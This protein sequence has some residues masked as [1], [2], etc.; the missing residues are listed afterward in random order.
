M[1]VGL[2]SGDR[3]GYRGQTQ[4]NERIADEDIGELQENP[5]PLAGMTHRQQELD[6]NVQGK[7]ILSWKKDFNQSRHGGTNVPPIFKI[8]LK[9]HLTSIPS[10]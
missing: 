3:I 7:K 2:E 8:A 9:N 6:L 5:Q 1:D 4:Y 10:A